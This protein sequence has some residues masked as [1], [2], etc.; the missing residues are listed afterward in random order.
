MTYVQAFINNISFPKTLEQLET[1][2]N[3]GYFDIEG[4]LKYDGEETGWTVPG[5]ASVGDISFFMHAKTANAHISRL[6]TQLRTGKHYY[7]EEMGQTMMAWLDRAR[8]I[9]REYGG[10][11]FAL[12]RVSSN[13]EYDYD[14]GENYQP[15]HWNS[16]IFASLDQLTL[17]DK[18]I[19]IS[20][21]NDFI[22]VSR[23][24]AITPV[25]GK[26]F[27]LLKQ[28]IS[29]K[30]KIPPFYEL[31]DATPYPLKDVNNENWPVLGNIYRRSFILESQLRTY[32]VDYLLREIGDQTVFYKE[33]RS[34]RTGQADTFIDNVVLIDGK[35]LPVE[36]KRS[37]GQERDLPGQLN[38][39]CCSEGIR[40]RQNAKT[41][42]PAEKIHRH[43][44]LVIDRD[45]VYLFDFAS[46]SLIRIFDLDDIKEVSDCGT[47]RQILISRLKQTIIQNSLIEMQTQLKVVNF[48]DARNWKQYHNPKDLAISLS[49]E[50]AE[51]LEIFQWS[52]SEEAVQDRF[53]NIQEELADVLM[54]AVLLA[55]E[56]ELDIN[57]IV[58]T[59]LV[60]NEQKYPVSMAYGK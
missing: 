3:V 4:L 21:F 26:E 35:Y 9:Y 53:D 57:E 29:S 32:Y 16:R 42:V 44:C 23:M 41:V 8:E 56:L 18:P 55:D 7:D 13:P 38:Q 47:L 48:R 6:T 31:S 11:I 52:S 10:K 59:K 51:L 54:Y 2:I 27:K 28:V 15:M 12:A 45:K 39:Y 25:L 20:E 58:Q 43:K 22:F 34:Y 49:I 19:D 24:S 46:Q 33:C 30:N 17:L 50:A 5:W 1:Y 37:V 14:E 40:L 36:I 60:K